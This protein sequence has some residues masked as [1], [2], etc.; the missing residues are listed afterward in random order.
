M[1]L[2]IGW[3]TKMNLVQ[4]ATWIQEGY[5]KYYDDRKN[6]IKHKDQTDFIMGYVIRKGKG[7]LNPKIVREFICLETSVP[8]ENG[9]VQC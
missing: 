9:T 1:K 2:L 7:K 4:I 5:R 3:G 6:G 8:D